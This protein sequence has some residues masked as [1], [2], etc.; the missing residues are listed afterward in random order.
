MN[1]YFWTCIKHLCISSKYIEHHLYHK[2]YTQNDGFKSFFLWKPICVKIIYFSDIHLFS[3]S[4]NLYLY[5]N[6]IISTEV[7]FMN[8]YLPYISN[9]RLCQ[10]RVI[11]IKIY[12]FLCLF[13]WFIT[14]TRKSIVFF[15]CV[16]VCVCA[17][18][19]SLQTY[20]QNNT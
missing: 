12:C 8:H 7:V 15:L 6:F 20:W 5:K 1:L 3:F 14:Q 4:Y 2:L 9:R 17:W 11:V 18:F 13:Q 19:Y 16:R 10:I